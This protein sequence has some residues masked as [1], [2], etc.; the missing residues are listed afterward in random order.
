[1]LWIINAYLIIGLIFGG[2]F[3]VAG[4]SRIDPIAVS[5]K[6]P[7]RLMWLPAALLLRPLFLIKTRPAKRRKGNNEAVR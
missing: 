7:V 1:M 5:A 2:Y 3:I 6:V 4:C